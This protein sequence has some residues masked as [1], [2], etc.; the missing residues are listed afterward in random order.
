MGTLWDRPDRMESSQDMT[1]WPTQH[2]KWDA[3]VKRHCL[4]HWHS[5]HLQT[6]VIIC[7]AV[8]SLMK[9]KHWV[10]EQLW[11]ENTVDC[12]HT[13]VRHTKR[14]TDTSP[15]VK[16]SRNTSLSVSFLRYAFRLPCLED[17]TEK[18]R[19]GNSL[20][21]KIWNTMETRSQSKTVSESSIVFTSEH[22]TSVC[23]S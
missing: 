20:E 17:L 22:W 23:C 7:A 8:A 11:H 10:G 2:S 1:W 5:N 4:C 13:K 21:T 6:G 14:K 15:S 16:L 19:V 18:S 12:Y 9:C 3:N